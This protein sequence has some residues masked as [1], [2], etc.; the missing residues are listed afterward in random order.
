MYCDLEWVVYNCI[1][2]ASLLHYA[3]G[4]YL[5]LVQIQY[6]CLVLKMS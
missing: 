3:N 5:N 1:V 2:N 6:H 4:Y